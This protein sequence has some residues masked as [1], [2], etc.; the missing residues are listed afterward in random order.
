MRTVFVSY[1]RGDSEGQARALNFELVKLIGKDSVFMDVDSI[2]LGQDFRHVLHERL[3]SCDVLLALIGPGWLEAKDSAGNRRLENPTDLVR[4]EIAAALSRNIPVTPVL[5]QGA[6]MP[7]PERLPEDIRDLVY[8]N[9]FE[10]GHSSWESDVSEMVKRLGLDKELVGQARAPLMAAARFEKKPWL[11]SMFVAIVIVAAVLFYRNAHDRPSGSEIAAPLQQPAGSSPQESAGAPSSLPQPAGSPLEQPDGAPPSQA[12][13]I[14]SIKIANLKTRTVEVYDQKS[15][16]S[17][18]TDDGYAGKITPTTTTLQVPAGTYKLKFGDYGGLFVEHVVVNAARSSEIVLG[19]ISIPNLT[20]EVGVYDQKSK[21]S[22]FT[23]D[24]Y[25]GKITP[26]TTTLQVPAGTYK[27]KFGDY[28][29]LFVEHVVVNAARSSEIVLGTISIPNLT[30]EVGVYDQ[31]SK[32]SSFT[33]DGYAGKIT[34]T[35]TTLQVPAGT[36]KLKFGDY[37]GLFVEHVVVNAARSSEIVL[38]TISIP[39]LTRE[40]EVYDQQ[41]KA[42]SFTDV[43]HAGNLTPTTRTLQVPAGMYKVKFGNAFVQPVRVESGKTVIVK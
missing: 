7:P 16:A 41:S 3:E 24:G 33:D 31:K 43:G 11:L 26:T 36:Y 42:S 5:L 34:P 20:R 17:S 38:G 13:G 30:R 19:T 28:G 23:D 6:Q 35:T 1:R 15:K 22:S 10:V 9:G 27:L 21:A 40:V 8:R 4:Q 29:G 32:A 12:A 25:A 14:G 18:F 2:A 37:G 39:N